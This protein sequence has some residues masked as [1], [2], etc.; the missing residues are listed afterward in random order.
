MQN[1]DNVPVRGTLERDDAQVVVSNEDGT[2]ISEQTA[3]R[4]KAGF[5]KLEFTSDQ[6][7]GFS[8]A[9]FSEVSLSSAG[10]EAFDHIHC[11]AA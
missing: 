9:H 5:D 10:L 8:E 3:M 1:Q 2:S 11:D 7:H 4:L 6:T